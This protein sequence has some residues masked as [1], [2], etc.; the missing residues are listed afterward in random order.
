MPRCWKTEGLRSVELV[1][2]GSQLVFRDSKWVMGIFK[3]N[4]NE[5][6]VRGV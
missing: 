2:I 4:G 1:R 6:R 3:E 5:R